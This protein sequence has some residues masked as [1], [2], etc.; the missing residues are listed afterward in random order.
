MDARPE[1]DE[2]AVTEIEQGRYAHFMFELERVVAVGHLVI[3]L[4]FK[5]FME[6]VAMVWGAVTHQRIHCELVPMPPD[7]VKEGPQQ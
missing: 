6:T 2:D 7:Q 4:D 3:E 5:E 1:T